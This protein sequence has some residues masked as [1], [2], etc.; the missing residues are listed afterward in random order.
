[1]IITL[2]DVGNTNIANGT[3]SNDSNNHTCIDDVANSLHGS[4]ESLL[5]LYSELLE[6]AGVSGLKQAVYSSSVI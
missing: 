3:F 5:Y 2:E 1:M 4:S 6:H